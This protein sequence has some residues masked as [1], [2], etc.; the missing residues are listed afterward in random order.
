MNPDGEYLALVEPDGTTIATAFAPKYPIQVPNV[1]FGFGLITSNTALV[2]TGAALRVLVPTVANGGSLLGDTWKGT[3]EPFADGSWRSGVSGVG[4]SAAGAP[5]LVGATSMAVRFNFDAAPVANAIVDSKP[6]GTPL[7]GVNNG[8]A[9]VAASADVS[10]TPITRSGAMQFV[11]T[12]GDLPRK[13]EASGRKPGRK[14]K[15]SLRF[16]DATPA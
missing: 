3:N 16:S 8:A 1:S 15:D 9:W 4:F 13:L 10:P 11:A 2:S 14:V 6:S 5:P 12:D 7:N